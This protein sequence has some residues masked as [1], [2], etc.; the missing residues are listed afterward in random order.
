MYKNTTMAL[1]FRCLFFFLTATVLHASGVSYRVDFEGLDDANTLKTIKAISQLTSLKKHPPASTNALRYRAESDVPELLK[2]LHAH[3][4]YEATVDIRLDESGEQTRVVVSIRPGP[5]YVLE[6]FEIRLYSGEEK[7]EIDSPNTKLH[8][9]GVRLGKPALA[10]KI[11]E[12]ELIL[13]QNLSDC[14][15]PLATVD[16]REVIVDGSMKDVRVLLEVQAGPRTHF[17]EME[18]EGN[19]RVS[20][21]VIEQKISWDE[22]D[23]Y[24]SSLVACT[25]RTLFNTGLFSSVLITHADDVSEDHALKMHIEVAESKH[26]SISIGASYQ[27]FFGPGITFGWEHRNISGLGRKLSFQGD[28]TKRSHSGIAV[29]LISDFQRIGQDYLWQAQAIHEEII[30]YSLRS[31]SLMNRLDRIVN[32]WLRVSAGGKFEKLYVT[33]SAHNGTY[34]LLE[35]PLY[36]R[37]STANNLLN[38]TRGITVEYLVTPSVNLE[39][40]SNSYLVQKLTQSVYW[41]VT[42]SE[43]V[44]LAQQ[45]T[46][47]S[48]VSDSLDV[49]PLPKRFLG[50]SEDELRGYR[51][52]TVSPL[53]SHHKPLGGRSAIFYTF[54]TRF[55]VTQT[56]GL[57][58]FFDLGNV[59][60]N[61][62]PTFKGKWFTSTG[63]GF[64]YFSFVGPLRLDL[65][66]ALNRR[67]DLDPPDPPY[68]ILLSMGQTF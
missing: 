17:G 21:K 40:S 38:P 48:I 29:Y 23:L 56:I 66:F 45:I 68:R 57:V 42:K 51:Y 49:I 36:A 34:W 7:Q 65:A 30:P 19:T 35:F 50:G 15:Y 8:H 41:P 26:R 61:P 4:Y 22:G 11:I 9:L 6:T 39:N 1:F 53:N 46:V 55:R 2:A 27:T 43:A 18:I 54:E 16:H 10:Q 25:Q 12:A 3:G 13:L 20:S 60:F 59:Y 64:R 58:P 44:V 37:W 47:G 28:I 5:V 62:L 14:G 63:L 67:K 24:N 52:L 33:S 32:D 31:Y